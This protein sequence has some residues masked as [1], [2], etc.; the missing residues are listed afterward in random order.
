MNDVI[1]GGSIF[2]AYIALAVVYAKALNHLLA[3]PSKRRR[4]R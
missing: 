3:Q 4:R 1:L 2:A